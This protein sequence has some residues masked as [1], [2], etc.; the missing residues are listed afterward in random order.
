M[1]Y[2]ILTFKVIV[3]SI[4][5]FFEWLFTSVPGYYIRKTFYFSGWLYVAIKAWAYVFG[6][7]VA[8]YGLWPFIGTVILFSIAAHIFS[9][10][11]FF[12]TKPASPQATPKETSNA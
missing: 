3:G 7:A 10:A 9:F 1:S 11:F 2:I 8:A 4:I 5:L 12:T 6:P